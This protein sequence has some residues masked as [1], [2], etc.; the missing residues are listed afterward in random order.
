MSDN[1]PFNSATELLLAAGEEILF[2]IIALWFVMLTI[3]LSP[4]TTSIVETTGVYSVEPSN[5]T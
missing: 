1:S 3:T 5:L 4:S 2:T